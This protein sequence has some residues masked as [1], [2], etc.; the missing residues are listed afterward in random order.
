MTLHQWAEKTGDEGKLRLIRRLA[1]K[2][3]KMPEPKLIYE[4]VEKVNEETGWPEKR[5]VVT[6]SWHGPKGEFLDLELLTG[7]EAEWYYIR[8]KEKAT[9]GY[10][11]V[12]HLPVSR[13]FVARLRRFSD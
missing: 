4:R 12:E 6:V 1:D 10:E 9:I 13:T 7:G 3:P 5:K 11:P 2:V 8:G